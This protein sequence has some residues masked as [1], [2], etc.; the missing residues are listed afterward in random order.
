MTECERTSSESIGQ[1]NRQNN[2]P[3]EAHILILRTRE[4]VT[5]MA[6]KDFADV[7][8]VMDLR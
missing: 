8:E 5:L 7:M 6:K 1:C 2:G 3:S 4:Y